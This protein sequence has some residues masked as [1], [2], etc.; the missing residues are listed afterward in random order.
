MPCS[1]PLSHPKQRY[2]KIIDFGLAK[3]VTGKTWTLCGTPD[4]LAPEIILNEGHDWG[5][6]YWTLGV[7]LFEMAEGLAPFASDNP[8]GVYKKVL[9]GNVTIPSHFSDDLSDLIVK[10]LNTTQSKR[11]GR[12]IGGGGAVM[13]HKW[14]SSLDWDALLEKSQKAP[15]IPRDYKDEEESSHT[16]E[17]VRALTFGILVGSFAICCHFP[18]SMRAQA[19]SF[20]H[21]A[22]TSTGN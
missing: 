22:F 20:P 9:S 15:F 8:M 21:T 11:F 7:L 19:H 16:A 18:C 10:L 3:I 13:Q 17:I 1:Y 5:V 14:Y 6:D 2:T 4:Y 12:T